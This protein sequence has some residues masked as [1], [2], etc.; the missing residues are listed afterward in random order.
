[1][2]GI[3]RSNGAT[4]ITLFESKLTD[5]I[6]GCG[7]TVHSALG[8]G[9]LESVY[10]TCLEYEL[11][12][13]GLRVERQKQLPIS[14]K[15]IKLDDSLRIDMVVNNLV[16]IELKCV[17]KLLPVHEAQLFTY[18]KLSGIRTGLLLNFYTKLLKD[19]IKRIVC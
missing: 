9:L 1:M 2:H 14:Y 4:E 11:K 10:E 17:D 7:V 5:V 19:G 15:D 16:I 12:Q 18:L 13:S 6:I 8:P 3:T